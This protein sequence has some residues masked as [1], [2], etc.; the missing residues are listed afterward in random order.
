M[1][2]S[3]KDLSCRCRNPKRYSSKA[4]GTA[5]IEAGS[6]SF[7]P[8]GGR[9]VVYIRVGPEEYPIFYMPEMRL[10][11]TNAVEWVAGKTSAPKNLKRRGAGPVA[12]ATGPYKSK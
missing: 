1:I 5:G 8:W 11:L 10:L 4:P 2:D 7:G 3:L 12:T 9:R 6:A